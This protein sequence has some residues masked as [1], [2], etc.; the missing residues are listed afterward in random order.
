MAF[1]K[2]SERGNANGTGEDEK[3]DGYAQAGARKGGG[4]LSPDVQSY[5]RFSHDIIHS[6]LLEGKAS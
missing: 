5:F 2:D 1:Q 3:I 4:V 6:V